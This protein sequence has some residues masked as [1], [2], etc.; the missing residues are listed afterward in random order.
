[1]FISWVRYHGRSAGIAAALNMPTMFYSE[2]VA[3]LPTPVRYIAEAIRTAK[4]LRVARPATVFLMLPPTV[5]LFTVLICK[6]TNTKLIVDLHTGFFSNPRW[7]WMSSIAL[8]MLS[9]HSALVTNAPLADRCKRA[10][11]KSIILHDPLSD[12]TTFDSSSRERYVLF[13]LN[14]A[15]DEPIRQ[16]LDAAARMSSTQFILTGRAPQS[17][18]AQASANVTFTGFVT[19]E[20]YKRLLQGASVVGALTTR[21]LTMQRA[22]YEALMHGK[23]QVTSDFPVLRDFL[24]GAAEYVDPTDSLAIAAALKKVMSNFDRYRDLSVDIL[25][26]R[27]KEQH[28]SL[29]ELQTIVDNSNSLARKGSQ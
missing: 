15:N 13:P 7:S 9:G 22:G 6:P 2:R 25:Q 20:E 10:G 18:R 21:D 1:M 28:Q 5:A 12:E 27:M 29:A 17:V 11:L 26:E 23:P 8:R 24:G 14:Y 3:A 4:A 19:N 16:I